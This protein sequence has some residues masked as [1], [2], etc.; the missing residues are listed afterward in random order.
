[1]A[2]RQ[3]LELTLRDRV[4]KREWTG[5][6]LTITADPDDTKTLSQFCEDM[7][8]DLDHRGNGDPWWAKQYAVRVK[9]LDEQWRDFVVAG[10]EG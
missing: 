5:Q 6:R 3:R 4:G 7:A 8:R 1:M 2:R 10:G 9:G